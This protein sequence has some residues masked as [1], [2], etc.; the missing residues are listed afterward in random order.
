MP[1]ENR[2][3]DDGAGRRG[4]QHPRRSAIDV[5]VGR[6]QR[7]QPVP[8]RR[9][10]PAQGVHLP[11]QPEGPEDP[12]LARPRRQAARG[13]AVH[14]ELFPDDD[15]DALF[16]DPEEF[17]LAKAGGGGMIT[18]DN[19]AQ[20]NLLKTLLAEK[21]AEACEA[22]DPEWGTG[23]YTEAERSSKVRTHEGDCWGHLRNTWFLGA[24]KA[25]TK[26]VKMGPADDLEN[27]ILEIANAAP[28]SGARSS[29]RDRCDALDV[30]V[31]D[32]RPGRQQL[33]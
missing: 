9:D 25:I 22:N 31:G 4:R 19:C 1:G 8:R 15:L 2:P 32:A 17:T 16:P 30:V 3:D 6:R 23:S 10:G 26:E 13:R 28:V 29:S 5:V 7:R 12:V 14:A 33:P 24:A 20:A 18:S 27:F 21:I 11:L